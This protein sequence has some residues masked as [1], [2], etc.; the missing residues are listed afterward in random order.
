MKFGNGFICKEC[1]VWEY[2]THLP[3]EELLE[4]IKSKLIASAEPG[5]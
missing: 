2:S 1:Y 3:K 5:V 4:L